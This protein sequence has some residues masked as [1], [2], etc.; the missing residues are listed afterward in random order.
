MSLANPFTGSFCPA[1]ARHVPQGVPSE[2]R[3]STCPNLCLIVA[4]SN[5]LRPNETSALRQDAGWLWASQF[6]RTKP[7]GSIDRA[8][9]V[10]W[11]NALRTVGHDRAGPGIYLFGG[12]CKKPHPP[13][14]TP[15][16]W[17]RF[18][19]DH[20]ETFSS[21]RFLEPTTDSSGQEPRQGRR[22]PVPP[23]A[24]ETRAVAGIGDRQ[25]GLGSRQGDVEQCNSSS[26]WAEVSMARFE[27]IAPSVALITMTTS[28]SSPFAEWIV[29]ST[30]KSFACADALA[31]SWV[32]VGGSSVSSAR[33]EARSSKRSPRSR[34]FRRSSSR[35]SG[36]S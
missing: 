18:E 20:A 35:C 24:L 9:Q 32:E 12:I 4:F 15:S 36:S 1:S 6:S 14:S 16:A 27:G 28:Y 31:R 23:V 8:G 34:S 19:T 25:P 3:G 33:N 13:G 11:R 5:P 21:V 22:F 29:L 26:S 30:R 7:A 2:T 10:P 17:H